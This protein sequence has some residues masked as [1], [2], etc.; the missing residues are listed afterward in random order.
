MHIPKRGSGGG[1]GKRATDRDARRPCPSTALAGA[2]D[3]LRLWRRQGPLASCLQRPLPSQGRQRKS[4]LPIDYL[5]F[6]PVQYAG[7]THPAH[8]SIATISTWRPAR[9]NSTVILARSDPARPIGAPASTS[10]P[11]LADTPIIPVTA[12]GEKVLYPEVSCGNYILGRFDAAFA[13][14]NKAHSAG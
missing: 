10:S 5:A 8:P 12:P 2:Q 14:R 9:R 13:Y 4:G 6:C 11:T 7:T 3:K 1:S